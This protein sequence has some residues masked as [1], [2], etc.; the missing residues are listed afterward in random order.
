MKMPSE[1]FRTS[2]GNFFAHYTKILRIKL[3]SKIFK[4]KILILRN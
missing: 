2:E 3:L 1:A 4:A